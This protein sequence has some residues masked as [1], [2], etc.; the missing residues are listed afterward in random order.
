MLKCSVA[1]LLMFLSLTTNASAEHL[2]K[3]I[4]FG[5][6]NPTIATLPQMLEKFGESPFDG[7]S[8]TATAH[9]QVFTVSA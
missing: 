7:I 8:V 3:L 4:H 6:D 2:V 5:W 9:D 1:I